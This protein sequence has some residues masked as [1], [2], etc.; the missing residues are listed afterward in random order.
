MAIG[1]RVLMGVAGLGLTGAIGVGTLPAAHAAS[2][3]PQ[4][5]V[6]MVTYAGA[7]A[8]A[9]A[10]PSYV[11]IAG[12]GFTSWGNAV[13]DLRDTATGAMLE[14]TTEEAVG[15]SS[16]GNIYTALPLPASAS[17]SV[18]V[19]VTDAATGAVSNQVVIAS[20]L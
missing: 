2:A 19:D 16:G 20:G 17:G 15:S 10:M 5:T 13:I 4:V 3:A 9:S 6:T 11:L 18:T 1:R 14:T 7:S 8:A 12:S